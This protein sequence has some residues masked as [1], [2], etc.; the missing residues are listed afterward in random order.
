V[1]PIKKGT[2]F[3][4]HFKFDPE[5]GS[6][7]TLGLRQRS[8]GIDITGTINSRGKITT[9]L[10]FK[11]PFYGLKLSAEA[12]YFREHYSFGYGITIGPQQ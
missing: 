6:T 5:Q 7:T 11:T 4:S 10:G 3:V 1:I 12:D 9:N 2:T 8:E